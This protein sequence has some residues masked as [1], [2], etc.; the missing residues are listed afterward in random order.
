MSSGN[1]SGER[2]YD[3]DIASSYEDAR[4]GE[5][6][7]GLEQDYM[8]EAVRGLPE[9]ASLL[10]VPTGTGR[11]FGD[12]QSRRL[13]VLGVD[14]SASMLAEARRRI[15]SPGISL[16]LGDARR[17]AKQDNSFDYVVCWRLLHLL[18]PEVL[19]EVVGELARVAAKI[20]YLQAYVRDRWH[21]PLR[22]KAFLSR[23][24]GKLAG[25]RRPA[26]APWSHIKSYAHEEAVLLNIFSDCGL[27][28]SAVDVLGSYGS[29]RVKVY[30]LNKA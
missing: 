11:F 12:Y 7:W 13:N 25:R 2:A 23:I 19:P 26:A 1:Y 15:T 21:H 18:P 6:I 30:V 17:L 5:K 20:I 29:L 27:S 24:P 14:I 9:G 10:D 28:V 3:S 16:E 8:G 22:L 4:K